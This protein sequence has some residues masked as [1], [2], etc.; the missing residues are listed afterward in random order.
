MAYPMKQKRMKE[1]MYT[2]KEH[3]LPANLQYEYYHG[4]KNEYQDRTPDSMQGATLIPDSW[5]SNVIMI[6]LLKW[7][8]GL[9]FSILDHAVS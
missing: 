3:H 2:G 1:H 9:G 8:G 4:Y 6:D 5:E 7:E